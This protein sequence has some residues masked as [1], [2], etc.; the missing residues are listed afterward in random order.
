MSI[1]YF[2]F[3]ML[4]LWIQKGHLLLKKS[5]APRKKVVYFQHLTQIE[6]DQWPAVVA[7]GL[8]N[9]EFV[10]ICSCIS[11]WHHTMFYTQNFGMS[12]MDL[13]ADVSTSGPLAKSGPR[14]L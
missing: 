6:P 3:L 2:Q 4:L 12:F 9:I 7:N 5:Y 10:F 11:V 1:V 13:V 14:R 8:C